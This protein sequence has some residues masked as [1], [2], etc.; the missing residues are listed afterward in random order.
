[1]PLEGDRKPF[2][3]VPSTPNTFRSEPGLSPD[4]RWL[5]YGSNE[6][7]SGQAYV[8]AF[9]GDSGKWQA[10]SNGEYR[11]DWSHDGKELFYVDGAN[12]IYAVPV[13]EVEGALQ[14]GAPQIEVSSS[15]WS[16]PAPLFQ[17]SPDGK[18]I[19]LYRVSQQ[20]SDSVTVITNFT[21]G[22]KK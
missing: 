16:S 11:V 18:K 19:L 13:K 5:A 14:F 1:M 17:V 9:K 8:V 6:S 7:G 22:L 10:S 15:S 20:V 21:A 2:Q 12:S 4:G 3:V